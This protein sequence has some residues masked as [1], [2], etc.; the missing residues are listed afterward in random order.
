VG[1]RTNFELLPMAIA[2]LR[3][4][5]DWGVDNIAATLAQWTA[6]IETE[7]RRR[8]LDPLP[9]ERRGP[10]MLGLSVPADH[11][12]TIGEQLAVEN[13]YVGMRGSSMRVSP[14]L[15]VTDADVERLF[16]AL[17]GAMA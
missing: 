8:G 3:Q 11:R 2:A 10:H 4:L 15:H 17:D 12:A 7:A 16:A 1:Q 6:R 9:A 5:L 13:V 14:H